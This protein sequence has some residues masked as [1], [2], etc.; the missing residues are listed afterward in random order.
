M[1]C[2]EEVKGTIFDFNLTVDQWNTAVLVTAVL[3]V[4]KKKPR[5]MH[6]TGC[7]GERSICQSFCSV[8]VAE[9]L[10]FLLTDSRPLSQMTL[11]FNLK[12]A[13]ATYGTQGG[14]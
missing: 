1:G 5:D 7:L 11:G 9:A 3:E 14:S 2:E 12:H 13:P 4:G 10:A 6:T 8:G